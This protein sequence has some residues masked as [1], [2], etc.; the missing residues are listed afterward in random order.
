MIP[1]SNIG[2]KEDVNTCSEVDESTGGIRAFNVIIWIFH[3]TSMRSGRMNN[4]MA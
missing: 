3:L 1:I 4:L 2:G